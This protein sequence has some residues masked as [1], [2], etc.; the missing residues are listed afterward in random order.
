MDGPLQ[1]LRLE[2]RI[3]LACFCLFLVVA[4]VVQVARHAFPV[5]ADVPQPVRPPMATEPRR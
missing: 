5:S 2:R 1:R 4:A 3:S